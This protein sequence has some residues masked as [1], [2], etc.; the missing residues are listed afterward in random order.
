MAQ[1][2]TLRPNGL[3]GSVYGSFAG[4]AEAE[5]VASQPIALTLYDRDFA[6]SL[7]DRVLGLTLNDRE[8]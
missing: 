4:K 7:E 2:T 8:E 1:Q 5:V 6:L 3:P